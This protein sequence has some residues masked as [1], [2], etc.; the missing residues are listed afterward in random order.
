MKSMKQLVVVA[1]FAALACTAL[2]AQSADLR[3]TIPFDFHAAG[4]LMPAGEYVIHEQGMLVVLREAD[5]GRLAPILMTIGVVS[6]NPREA[7]LDFSH[8]GNEYF[9]KAIWSP[10]SG[11]G[12]QFLQTAREREVAKRGIVPVQAEVTLASTK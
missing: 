5:S 6:S 2:H 11:Y 8:Y 10:V 1:I 4:K 7:G 3:A 12:R 9:L